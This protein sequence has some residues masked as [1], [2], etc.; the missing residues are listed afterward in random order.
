MLTWS[1]SGFPGAT[2][3]E[4][5]AS[6]RIEMARNTAFFT[7]DFT[8]RAG[9]RESS[10]R[11]GRVHAPDGAIA[12]TAELVADLD[13]KTLRR[14]QRLH[15]LVEQCEFGAEPLADFAERGMRGFDCAILHDGLQQRL[16]LQ[17]FARE[18]ADLFFH[19]T[20]VAPAEYLLLSRHR[21]LAPAQLQNRA[22]VDL[23]EI[24]G[25]VE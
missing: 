2:A 17:F 15:A 25:H 8:Y 4:A 5:K 22:A 13:R 6:S 21:R 14:A 19:P 11:F 23:D 3:R 9:C 20:A 18:P 7:C 16:A 1:F 12:Q 24:V 10:D